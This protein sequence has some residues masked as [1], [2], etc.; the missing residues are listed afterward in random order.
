M[1]QNDNTVR[2]AIL[3][4][5]LRR[6]GEES[7]YIQATDQDYLLAFRIFID[8]LDLWDSQGFVLYGNRPD[9]MMSEVGT[10]DPKTA[11]YTNLVMFLAP[12]FAYEPTQSD[13]S[14]AGNSL[15]TIR[16][17]LRKRPIMNR[18]SRMPRGTNNYWYN[19]YFFNEDGSQC[20]STSG[21]LVTNNCGSLV[22]GP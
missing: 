16:N 3:Q 11:L 5:A 4:R 1:S 17:R 15:R 18:P 22:T 19:Y 20:D 2:T 7:D 12:E 13:R 8:M 6:V 9:S 14:Q 10:A 21:V